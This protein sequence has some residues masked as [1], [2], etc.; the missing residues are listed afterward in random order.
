MATAKRRPKREDEILDLDYLANNSTLE[1]ML[2][3]LKPELRTVFEDAFPAPSA[4]LEPRSS[5]TATSIAA[6]PVIDPALSDTPIT[7]PPVTISPSAPERSESTHSG[8]PVNTAPLRYT[9]DSAPFVTAGPAIKLPRGVALFR[10]KNTS[11]C[12][13]RGEEQVRA[14]LW[15]S[16]GDSADDA[17][18]RFIEI[19][20]SYISRICGLGETQTRAALRG[21]IEKLAIVL[22]QDYHED[23]RPRRYRIRSSKIVNQI[24]RDA[25]LLWVLRQG[26]GV[27]LLDEADARAYVLHVG[28]PAIT[29]AVID[30]FMG[31]TEDHRQ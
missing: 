15:L 12:H 18:D 31:E 6:A 26:P 29:S 1:G 8:G 10:W 2:S 13:N 28:G 25:G 17:L 30:S 16:A 14:K 5:E 7:T 24:R 4:T 27:R 19:P 21:L 3:H 20:Q 22:E 23:G 9:S 11:E